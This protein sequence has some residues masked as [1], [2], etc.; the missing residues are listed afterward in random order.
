VPR[1]AA[2][3]FVGASLACYNPDKDPGFGCGRALVAALA[4]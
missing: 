4:G 3:G 1:G 2:E